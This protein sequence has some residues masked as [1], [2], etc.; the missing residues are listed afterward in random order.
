LFRHAKDAI[1]GAIGLDL[2][3]IVGGAHGELALQ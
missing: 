2:E 1:G 3:G